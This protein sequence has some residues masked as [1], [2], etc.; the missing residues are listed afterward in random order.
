[1]LHDRRAYRRPPH[2]VCPRPCPMGRR[3]VATPGQTPLL[4]P[5]RPIGQDLTPLDRV[6]G[7]T[8]RQSAYRGCTR[9]D[10]AMP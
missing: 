3:G 1:M 9:V 4:A 2:D 10:G 5:R 7:R 6:H 8:T